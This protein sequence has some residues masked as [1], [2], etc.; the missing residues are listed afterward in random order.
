MLQLTIFPNAKTIAMKI[1]CLLALLLVLLSC[2]AFS[3]VE[4]VTDNYLNHLRNQTPIWQ[5]V[6][7]HSND[8]AKSYLHDHAG[9]VRSADGLT[10]PVVVHIVHNGG[11]ENISDEQVLQCISHINEAF[12]N[13]GDYLDADGVNTGISLCL[14]ARDENNEYTTGINRLQS[15]YT[16]M[17]TPSEDMNL[18]SLISWNPT[19]Y[20]NIWVVNSITGDPNQT[21][22]AGYATLPFSHGSPADGIV[23]EAAYFGTSTLSSKVMIHEL[24]H[25]CGL[26]HTFEGSCENDDCMSS[27]DK[28]CDTPPDAVLFSAA[29]DD[30]MNSCSTDEDDLSNNNPFR[31]V[32]DGGLGDQID[33]QANYM[34]YSGL[35]CF[36]HFT[37]GQADRMC[38]LIETNRS[39]LLN[40]LQC[41]LPC[42]LPIVSSFD[43]SSTDLFVGEVLNID[44]SST[45]FTS[46]SWFVNG[47]LATSA[48]DFDYVFSQIG[49]Y[50]ITAELNN[51]DEACFILFETVVNVSCGVDLDYLVDLEIADVDESITAEYLG[52]DNFIWLVDGA[53]AGSNN[54][55]VL[56]FDSPGLH[57]IAVE[58]TTGACSET[59]ASTSLQIGI[60]SGSNHGNVWCMYSLGDDSY[61]FDFNS[62]EI[63][64]LYGWEEE[65]Y[66]AK[67]T[68]ADENGVMQFTSNGEKVWGADFNVLQNGS[69]LMGS[70]SSRNGAIIMKSPGDNEL[71]YLFYSDGFEN[72]NAN[73]VRY[74]IIDADGN[75]GLG[76]VTEKNT[77]VTFTGEESFALSYHSNLEDFWLVLFDRVNSRF[78]SYLVTEG[79][80]AGLP[81]ITD[82]GEVFV[83]WGSF[84]FNPQGNLFSHEDVLY[85]FDQLTGA[86]TMAYNF[87]ADYM[88]ANDFSPDGNQLY[89]CKGFAPDTY[90]ERWDVSDLENVVLTDSQFL[91]V[92][93]AA[94]D[95]QLAPDG[96]IYIMDPFQD[97]LMRVEN[98]NNGV[99]PIN[100]NSTFANIGYVTFEFGTIFHGLLTGPAVHISGSENA[101]AGESLVFELSG[102]D[103]QDGEVVWTLESEE[104]NGENATIIELTFDTPGSYTLLGSVIG[105]CGVRVD[106]LT[107]EVHDSPLVDLPETIDACN[108]ET[109]VLE[110]VGDFS[111]LEWQDGSS[112]PTYS[113]STSGIYSVTAANGMGCTSSDSTEVLFY[114][115][116]PIDLGP[117]TDLCDGLALV[118]DSGDD[119]ASYTWQ[120]GS[121]GNTFTVSE[122]GTYYVTATTP[123][124]STDTIFVDGCGGS[125]D[126]VLSQNPLDELQ[127]FPNPSSSLVHVLGI[128][129]SIDVAVDL[130]DANGRLVYRKSGKA[131]EV[132]PLKVSQLESGNYF[133]QVSSNQFTIH[134][135][136]VVISEQ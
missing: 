14:A 108:G 70:N 132:F 55:L 8:Q 135:K 104:L 34:D 57:S 36:T 107:I 103:T 109:V 33:D 1:N 30:G 120:D 73:G 46:I 61:I 93:T 19:K 39:S 63:E 27:G 80:V 74:S 31:P 3:Q 123:C 15:T 127:L 37:D 121:P 56:S 111:S 83:G 87:N 99:G 119:Y 45:G 7:E 113:V 76:A 77:F 48:N 100:L 78:L 51:G 126:N 136:L 114:S 29:C 115:P 52:T 65:S 97:Y 2:S 17:F 96:N 71:Y 88:Y 101:C 94:F 134:K 13:S 54:P 81:T 18:K 50:T 22:V 122:G 9:V 35:P 124:F 79:G 43:V 131:R 42:D 59:A 117:D 38:A 20:L 102:P 110:A 68:W 11:E 60:C 23:C 85:H 53:P 24:G 75:G 47:E 21:G 86:I 10:I 129:A 4:C 5:K 28:V 32:A 112:E 69:G 82:L 91:P 49:T 130:T 67:T 72:E 6:E 128:S 106:D 90:L 40:G 95:C 66:E 84:S 89:V 12:A 133:L 26:Y 25:Y 41:L 44:N 62:G 116:L 125:I 64:F 92:E 16:D 118:L 58:A 98:A 105:A